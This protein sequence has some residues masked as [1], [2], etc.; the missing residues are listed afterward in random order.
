[1]GRGTQTITDFETAADAISQQ[2]TDGRTVTIN[3]TT[4][5]IVDDD[6]YE[7]LE[8]NYRADELVWLVAEATA[9]DGTTTKAW[10]FVG[11]INQN[12]VNRNESGVAEASMAFVA[13]AEYEA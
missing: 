1:D 4:N 2:I 6:G 7:L 11:F 5:L 10:G 8:E 13:N 9:I 3:F 12:N